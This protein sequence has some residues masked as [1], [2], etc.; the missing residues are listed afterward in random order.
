MK[1]GFTNIRLGLNYCS[2]GSSW[3]RSCDT[4]PLKSVRKIHE[5]I[6]EGKNLKFCTPE[7]LILSFWFLNSHL[8]RDFGSELQQ[9]FNS[10]ID[11]KQTNIYIKDWQ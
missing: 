5:N 9:F 10:D 7:F 11:K 4:V 8:Y 2:M 6:H 1:K 3:P